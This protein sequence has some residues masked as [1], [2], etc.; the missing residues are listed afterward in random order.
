[1]VRALPPSGVLK[2]VATTITSASAAESRS[3]EKR[4]LATLEL[5]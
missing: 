3:L 1:M 4:V 5:S 2:A